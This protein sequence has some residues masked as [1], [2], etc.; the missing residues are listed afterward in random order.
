[1]SVALPF[2]VAGQTVRGKRLGT[3]LGFPTANLEYPVGTA[4]PPNGVY[5][6]EAETEGRRYA[7]ILN[8]GTHPT[9][10]EGQATI[11]T[12]L[13]NYDGG[14]LYGRE[15]TLT[16]LRYL[17]PERRFGS[18]EELKARLAADEAEALRWYA[19]NG[20]AHDD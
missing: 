8:Q 20:R 11:E 10:P 1:M 4:L 19:E 17:R 15:I 3:E 5:I 7:A 6:A 12:H 18:L 2:T 13:L 9:A 16:Y 14:D